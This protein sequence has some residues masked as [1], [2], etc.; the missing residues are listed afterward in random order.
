MAGGGGGGGGSATAGGLRAYL[1]RVPGALVWAGIFCLWSFEYAVAV[2]YFRQLG[3]STQVSYLL[4]CAGPLSGLLVGP[5]VGVFS[6][7]CTS[8]YGRRRPFICGGVCSTVVA[9]VLFAS[10][11]TVA[12]LC[13]VAW[14]QALAVL[15]FWLMDL[16]INTIQNP[17]RAL[18]SDVSTTPEEQIAA[19][20]VIAQFCGLGYVLG[21]SIVSFWPHALE[22]LRSV[23]IV[24]I[25]LLL[26]TAA[27]TISQT[28]ETP[29]AAAAAPPPREEGGAEAHTCWGD[30]RSA[31]AQI[32]GGLRSM[33]PRVRAIA[34]CQLF[35][36]MGW[37]CFSPVLTDLFGEVI[38]EGS[39]S[40][41]CMVNGTA[42]GSGGPVQAAQCHPTTNTSTTA[43]IAC[44]PPGCQPC[45]FSAESAGC[46]QTCK[47]DRGVSA[48]SLGLM[49]QNIVTI[50]CSIAIPAAQSRCPGT[51][52]SKRIYTFSLACMSALMFCVALLN[53][54][55][56]VLTTLFVALMG[57]A[58]FGSQTY[59]YALM[60][61]SVDKDK[62][63][64]YMGVLTLCICVPQ[65]LDVT[66]TGQLAVAYGLEWVVFAGGVWSAIAVLATRWLDVPGMTPDD[67]GDR[68]AAAAG[69]N[70]G[71]HRVQ[72]DTDPLLP[73]TAHLSEGLLEA[74]QPPLPI[75]IDDPSS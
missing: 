56:V 39:P 21:F 29:T 28:K 34:L 71:H 11:Q 17:A 19:Q 9:A 64:L 41:K 1:R 57:V 62:K 49:L 36:W 52:T 8:R 61:M 65:L 43:L 46:D 14:A 48:G 75:D 5:V 74:D 25:S 3:F 10:A 4:W 53:A 33:T 45:D 18:V 58:Q 12:H 35:T 24:G 67:D 59:P 2:P 68:G 54:K 23:Y 72:R 20:A 63:G 22:Q 37:F 51:L 40:A 7:R 16:S 6:D 26:V 27:V 66:Y 15:G 42:A 70:G 13:E 47:Y 30:V 44:E 73:E 55:S 31:F 38:F 50:L 60:G 69:I 32:F